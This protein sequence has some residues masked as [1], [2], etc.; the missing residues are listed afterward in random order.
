MT[1]SGLGLL[2]TKQ[3][4][5]KISTSFFDPLRLVCRVVLQAKL[6]FQ[7]LCELKVDWDEVVDGDVAKIWDRILKDL[8]D[9]RSI[10]MPRFVLSY[11]REKI[12]SLELHGFC[13][14]SNVAY[15]VA[16]YVRVVMLVGVVVNLLKRLHL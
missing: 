13:D 9:C 8:K 15:A 16:V 2:Y 3:N 11:V 5:L 1:E 10:C 12:V 14:S 4:I 7:E 6:L